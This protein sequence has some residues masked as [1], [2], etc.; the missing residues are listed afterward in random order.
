MI[1][2]ADYLSQICA[3]EAEGLPIPQQ[4]ARLGIK[5]TT[6]VGVRQRLVRAGLIAARGRKRGPEWTDAEKDKLICLV[7]A[8][9]GYD[10]IAR[11]LKRTRTAVILKAKRLGV[12][13]TT[14]PATLAARDVAA[15]LGKG[16]SK[17]VSGWITHGWLKA[18]NAGTPQKPLWRIDW[19][20]LTDFLANPA[21]WS[22]WEPA[23][24][25]DACLREWAQELRAN[26]P[27]LLTQQEVARRYHVTTEA[28][29]QWL[30]KGW[31]PFVRA[32]RQ[33]RLIPE[34]A[35]A[36]WVIPSERPGE[37]P[38]PHWPKEGWQ[39]LTP[40]LRRWRAI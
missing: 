36:G 27:R 5:H 40:G 16:C 33:N 1:R 26:E 39:E 29:A 13:V 21:Y 7:E 19:E 15:L 24:I 34:T 37:L 23:R 35:L 38:P 32:G 31:M 2:A 20:A 8:G 11:R 3:L 14:T 25:T 10:T 4:A 18:R 22:T 30:D 17:S 28:V 9:Y 6:Y 12:R